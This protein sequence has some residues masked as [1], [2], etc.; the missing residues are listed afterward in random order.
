MRRPLLVAAVFVLVG[1]PVAYAHQP[2]PEYE[3]ARPSSAFLEVAP[4]LGLGGG[5][6]D[7][8]V[9]DRG[10]FVLSVDVGAT[11]RFSDELRAGLWANARTANFATFEPVG[12]VR[13]AWSPEQV[14]W[15]HVNGRWTIALDGGAGYA[16][17]NSGRVGLGDGAVVVGRVSWGFTAPLRL[18]DAYPER[19]EGVPAYPGEPCTPPAGVV[20]G[21]RVYAEVRRGLAPME[22]WEVTMGLE[23]EVLGSAWFLGGGS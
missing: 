3:R 17:R 21:F 7:L 11:V 19:C 8:G 12:G 5:A 14:H 13:F 1:A 20:S 6:Y 10:A 9:R 23:A 18:L 16:V 2:P 15:F 22:E 4:W